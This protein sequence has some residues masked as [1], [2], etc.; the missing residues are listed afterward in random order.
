MSGT[1]VFCHLWFFVVSLSLGYS[2]DV[3]ESF[4]VVIPANVSGMRQN[5]LEKNDPH[6]CSKGSS[7]GGKSTYEELDSGL[8]IYHHEK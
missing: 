7:L 3:V 6:Q 2:V 5:I 1:N 8:S 4:L